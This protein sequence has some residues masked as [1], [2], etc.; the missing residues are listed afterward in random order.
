MTKGSDQKWS[1]P[2]LRVDAC[3][4]LRFIGSARSLDKAPIAGAHADV[5]EG[6]ITPRSTNVKSGPGSSAT[7]STTAATAAST[8]SVAETT[9]TAAVFP[10]HLPPGVHDLCGPSSHT[11]GKPP[12]RRRTRPTQGGPALRSSA[13]TPTATAAATPTAARTTVTAA[14]GK[15]V[16]PDP[17]RSSGSRRPHPL[18][19][20]VAHVLA[21]AL[22]V[23]LDR[24][25][26]GCAVLPSLLGPQC[27]NLT[28][29][30]GL[31]SLGSQQQGP[32]PPARDNHRDSHRGDD[33][34]TDQHGQ[35]V[36]QQP[37]PPQPPPPPPQPPPLPHPPP[38]QPLSPEDGQPS[39]PVPTMPNEPAAQMPRDPLL[40]ARISRR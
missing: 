31:G 19:P 34:D 25:A 17:H 4:V 26:T 3:L 39:A 5:H 1:L 7:A 8:T 36:H 12:P 32:S 38:P 33:H 2:G 27:G 40:P 14:A 11:T 9:S 6:E 16:R 24:R 35:Y 30:L 18:G 13:P 22:V 10:P 15:T 20:P 21:L 23:T 37:P 29:V 28:P